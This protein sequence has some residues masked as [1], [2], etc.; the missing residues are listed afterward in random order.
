[1]NR[2]EKRTPMRFQPWKKGDTHAP[3]AVRAQ[4]SIQKQKKF[5]K[6][7]KQKEAVDNEEGTLKGDVRL[8]LL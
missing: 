3:M 2:R 1:M 7:R 4:K 8:I 6:I 5:R